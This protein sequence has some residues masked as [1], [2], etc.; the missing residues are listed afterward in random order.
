MDP[1]SVSASVDLA[2]S[3]WELLEYLRK[4]AGADVISAYFKY[5]GTRIEGS[6]KIDIELHPLEGN[7][8]VWWY[9]VKGLEDY[10]FLREPV[11]P[12]CAHE[13]VG[14]VAG[15]KLPDSRYWRW[16]APV[17]PG[18]IYGGNEPPNLKIDF[19]IFGYRPR[20]LLKHFG[21]K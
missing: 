9:S 8:A 16:I 1:A 12:S 20:A 7:A 2:K 14:T 10:V 5:D 19:L 13:M 4:V 21:S 17:L 3:G 11:T 18:R 15:E 6:S